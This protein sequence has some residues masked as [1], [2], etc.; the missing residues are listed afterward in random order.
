M[1]IGKKQFKR[2]NK[3]Y[4]MGILNITPDSFSDGGNYTQMDKALFRAAEMISEGADLLDVGGESTR[5]GYIKIPD[6]EEIERVVPVIERLKCEFDIPLSVDTYKATVAKAAIAAGVDMVN[7]IW[8]L[9]YDDLM[10]GV[11][12]KGKVWCC[13][14]H[15]KAQAEY[16][17]FMKDLQNELLESVAIG[18]KAGIV[19]EKMI[20]DPGIGFGK[21]QSNN[22]KA[23]GALEQLHALGFPL[24]LGTSRKSV[25]GKALDL[26][27]TKR[28]EGTLVTTA[29]AVMKGCTFIRV[30]DIKENRRALE[31]ATAIRNE[32]V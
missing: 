1:K 3:S 17:D 6:Q 10:A 19:K 28:L 15:N 16:D 7:D 31:M 32:M 22:L 5:P 14:M 29:L 9:K 25:I 18:E 27:V 26:P 21:S 4:L 12:A 13:L 30:H 11:I 20:L 2:E 8:G 24:L 23:I